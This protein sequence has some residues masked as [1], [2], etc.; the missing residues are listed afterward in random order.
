MSCPVPPSTT[1]AADP[2]DGKTVCGF[3]PAPLA[4]DGRSL[5][6][7]SY[8]CIYFGLRQYPD[9]VK[10]EASGPVSV[11]RLHPKDKLVCNVTVSG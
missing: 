10:Q 1:V 2:L 11:M 6:E 3:E 8:R 9:V 5:A 4:P 7:V